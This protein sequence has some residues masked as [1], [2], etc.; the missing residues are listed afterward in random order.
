MKKASGIPAR[1]VNFI[2]IHTLLLRP[3]NMKESPVHDGSAGKL[4][5][6]QFSG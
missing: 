2:R 1:R 3:K 4:G 6:E 5:W